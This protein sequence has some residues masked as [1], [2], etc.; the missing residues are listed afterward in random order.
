MRATERNNQSYKWNSKVEWKATTIN[1]S[2][3]ERR[4]DLRSEWD[5]YSGRRIARQ[6]GN[7]HPVQNEN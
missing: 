5:H 4:K 3:N 2:T 7:R 1:T 6:D